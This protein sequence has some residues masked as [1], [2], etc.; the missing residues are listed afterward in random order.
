MATILLGGAYSNSQ[1]HWLDCYHST[2]S[3]GL[4]WVRVDSDEEISNSPLTGGT[5]KA[6]SSALNSGEGLGL[7]ACVAT[8][9]SME[10]LNITDGKSLQEI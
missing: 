1:F 6:F 4:T 7:Y 3:E 10:F 8:D 2:Y 9:G 5:R